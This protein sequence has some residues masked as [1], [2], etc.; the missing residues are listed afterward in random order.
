MS[1]Q[2]LVLEHKKLNQQI[3]SWGLRPQINDFEIQSYKRRRCAL[4]SELI[5]RAE[6]KDQEAF[7]YSDLRK[8]SIEVS[9]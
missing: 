2:A 1:S 5:Q 9:T 3:D 7:V 8:W 6:D 4:K